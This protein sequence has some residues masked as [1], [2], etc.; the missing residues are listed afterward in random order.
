M[1]TGLRDHV[2]LS[3]VTNSVPLNKPHCLQRNGSVWFM[4]NSLRSPN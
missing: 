3:Y 4:V 2:G 1:I